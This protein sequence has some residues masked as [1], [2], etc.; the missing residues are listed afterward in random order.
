MLENGSVQKNAI[1]LSSPVDS[2]AIIK[3]ERKEN[4]EI[5]VEL[6]P[7]MKIFTEEDICIEMQREIIGNFFLDYWKIYVLAII[8]G[9]LISAFTKTLAYVPPIILILDNLGKTY[10]DDEVAGYISL[11]KKYAHSQKYKQ[12]WRMN[13]AMHMVVNAYNRLNKVPTV[14][15]AKKFSKFCKDSE[16]A[17]VGRKFFEFAIFALL[18][19]ITPIYVIDSFVKDVLG[20]L[21]F[22]L[23]YIFASA[24]MSKIFSKYVEI[25]FLRKPSEEDLEVVIA[26][27][28]RIDAT[29]Q[30]PEEFIKQCK[31]M[32]ED[33][34]KK[35][36]R[37]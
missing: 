20:D 32:S 13:A 16:L 31:Q 15:E 25:F 6:L 30:N 28:E 10:E 34:I 19:A 33:H 23:L 18:T 14:E 3:S 2:Y 21:V 26:A 4:G 12:Y 22:I 29:I 7:H 1:I 37:S 11:I 9:I 35:F 27:V 36:T 17:T 8:G 24:L 5:K